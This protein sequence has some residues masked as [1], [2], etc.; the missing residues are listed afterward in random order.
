MHRA[1]L[2]YE[3]CNNTSLEIIENFKERLKKLDFE[4][5]EFDLKKFTK[6]TFFGDFEI[7]LLGSPCGL[8]KISY[9]LK[10]KIIA[11]IPKNLRVN[12][13]I[14]FNTCPFKISDSRNCSDCETLLKIEGINSVTSYR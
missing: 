3:I 6:Q 8:G 12:R 13:I 7:L 11:L 14:T 4:I 1:L 2:L 9:S 10:K 5:T